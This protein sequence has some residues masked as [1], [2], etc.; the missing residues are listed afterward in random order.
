MATTTWDLIRAR[1]AGT[2]T[3]RGVLEQLTPTLASDKPWRRAARRNVAIRDWAKG[4][5]GEFRS[6]TWTRSGSAGE[7]EVFASEILRREEATLTVAYPIL[8]ALYGVEDDDSVESLI[9]GDARQLRDALLSPGNLISG[10]QAVLPVIQPPERGEKVWFQDITCTLV[11]FE[12]ET[13]T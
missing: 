1:F 10:L 13:L 6:Y 8:H 12:A 3:A 5:S 11:Y 4:N 7:P 9:R 2:T